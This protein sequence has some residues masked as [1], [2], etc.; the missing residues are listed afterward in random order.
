[1]FQ[2]GNK[3]IHWAHTFFMS[4]LQMLNGE[5]PAPESRP[6]PTNW[7]QTLAGNL[8]LI[9]A[10]L[11]LG[12]SSAYNQIK[13]CELN[14][15]QISSKGKVSIGI[16]NNRQIVVETKLEYLINVNWMYNEYLKGTFQ[17]KSI[18]CLKC[19]KIYYIMNGIFIFFWILIF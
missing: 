7:L 16:S 17:L 4:L 9:S 1:M 10:H 3:Y 13:D 12:L 18:W 15:K 11:K 19:A 5:L 2:E 6:Q 14:V 8:R